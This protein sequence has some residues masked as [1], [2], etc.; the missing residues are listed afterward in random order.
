MKYFLF[1]NI[2]AIYLQSIN[3][4]YIYTLKPSY[5]EISDIHLYQLFW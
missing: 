3:E 5:K 2:I 4:L 1:Y